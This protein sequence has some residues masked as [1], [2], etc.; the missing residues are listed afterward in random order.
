M[1][2]IVYEQKNDEN[3]LSSKKNSAQLDGPR[4]IFKSL[5]ENKNLENFEKV[6]DKK[7]CVESQRIKYDK[8]YEQY[9]FDVYT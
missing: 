5:V 8:S 9:D 1:M 2:H 4:F 3:S 7:C 6:G